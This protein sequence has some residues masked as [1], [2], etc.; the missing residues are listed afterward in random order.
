MVSG[1][2]MLD[3]ESTQS[4]EKLIIDNEIIGMVKRF[5]KGIEDYGTPFAAE[6][7]KDYEETQELLS[8]PTTLKHFRKELFIPSPIIDRTTRDTWKTLGSKSTRKRA[9]EEAAKLEKKAPIKPIDES[10][11]KNLDKIVENAL[12]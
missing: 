6:I 3:F 8:H 4:I 9:R 10:L 5:I 12:K 11:V 7:I 1:P 2:G